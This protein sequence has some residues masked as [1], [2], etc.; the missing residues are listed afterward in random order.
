MK[1]IVTGSLGN[2]SKPLTKELVQNG[3]SVTVI[4]S[5]PEKQKDIEALGATA[6][7]GSIDDVAF[8]TKT[9]TGSDAVYCMIP[10]NFHFNGNLD[11]TAYYRGIG[12][13][14]AQ[15]IQQSGVKRVVHLSSVGAHLDKDSGIILAHHDMEQALKKIPG[16]A[17][18]HL[19]P[20]AF[21][22]NLLGFVGAIKKQGVIASNYGADDRVPWVSPLDIAAVAA[23]ELV[24]LT[25]GINVRYVASD[26]LTCSEVARILGAA[27]G[28]PD[29]KWVIKSSEETQ[30]GLEAAG[31]PPLVAAGLVEMN[32]S[33]HSGVLFE[34]YYRNRPAL[35]KTKLTDFAKEFAAAFK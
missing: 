3:H 31:V 8:L 16:I 5:N 23:K 35:G 6:A 20:T 22:Y 2:I 4:S 27:I 12:E 32:A 9:F 19:R 25:E 7:I 13:T 29:L 18:T 15:A 1:I 34:D 11:P 28:K 17:L 10:P 24:T 26:E 14:Y 30:N 21:Y 33:M